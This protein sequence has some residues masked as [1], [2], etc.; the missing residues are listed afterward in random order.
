MELYIWRHPK[1]LNAVGVCLGHTDMAVD[2]RKL[3]RL[4][5]QIQRFARRHQLPKV[6]WVSPL[7]RSLEVGQIL[8]TR[9][10]RCEVAPALTELDFG[11]WDGQDWQQI[12]K[13]E[14]DAWC[15]DF[16]NYAPGG[17]ENLR[18]LFDRVASWLNS[19][20]PTPQLAVGHAGWIA[21]ANMLSAGRTVPATA[22][23]WP[24]PVAYRQRSKLVIAA[25]LPLPWPPRRGS[26]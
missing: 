25:A 19:L 4:A 16:A 1:P 6:I 26:C 12:A 8:A 7:Q 13:P 11:D 22:A 18:Q 2:K 20:P 10:F 14:I 15:D 5:N 24:R 9:G 17:G 21:A 3:S 23:D